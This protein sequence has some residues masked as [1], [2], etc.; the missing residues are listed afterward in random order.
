MNCT[1]HHRL[2]HKNRS[3]IKSEDR[4]EE[5]NYSMVLFESLV[6]LELISRVRSL[7]LAQVSFIFLKFVSAEALLLLF[8]FLST[9]SLGSLFQLLR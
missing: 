9:E 3:K 2:K 6:P 4:F 5:I 1:R 8:H 7:P